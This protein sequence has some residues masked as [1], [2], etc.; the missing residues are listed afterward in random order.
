M[1]PERWQQRS[2]DSRWLVVFDKSAPEEPYGLFRLSLET[3]EK[4]RLTSPPMG[5]WADLGPSLSPDDRGLVFTRLISTGISDLYLIALSEDLKPRGEPKR[6]TFENRWSTSPVWAPDGREIIFS[7]G[8][9]LSGRSLWRIEASGLSEPFGKPERLASVGEGSYALAISRQGGRLAYSWELTDMNIW[10]R[11]VPGPHGTL[12]GRTSLP[13]NFISSTRNE[14]DP[15]FSPDG[16]RIAFSSDRSGSTEIWV[17]DSDGSNPVQLTSFDG[18]HIVSPGWSADGEQIV[19]TSRPKGNVDIYII[20]SKGG[21]PRRLTNDPAFDTV[22][23]FSRNGRWIYFCSKRSGQMQVWKMPSSGGDAVQVTRKGGHAAFESP[24]GKFLYY[25]KIDP[26]PITLWKVP[27]EG[28]EESQVSISLSNDANFAVV[29]EG[30]YFIP[31]PDSSASTSLQFLS[32]KTGKINKINEINK[33]VSWGLAVSPDQRS[34]L[35]TQVDQ[36]SSDLVL[37]ENFR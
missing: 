8:E 19:F 34:F 37:V 7:S 4:Q 30:L 36:A 16:K 27:A 24:N 11:E 17:C 5:W 6:L 12:D 31:V 29:E 13:R 21:A 23:S 35:W 1:T 10:R 15:Q 20:S 14:S 9:Y 33:P 2:S 3:G 26:L 28:G 18:P 25:G 32:F 22:P